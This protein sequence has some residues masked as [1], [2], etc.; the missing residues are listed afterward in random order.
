MTNS[1]QPP[2]ENQQLSET[3]RFSAY[4]VRNVVLQNSYS[5]DPAQFRDLTSKEPVLSV[6]AGALTGGAIG[7]GSTL[8]G[9]YLDP[10]SSP[11]RWEELALVALV[12][13]AS[14][15]HT[16]AGTFVN[17]HKKKLMKDIEKYFEDNPRE[18]MSIAD[19]PKEDD[20]GKK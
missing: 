19:S 7:W 5:L 16:L 3:M 20:D 1:E 11:E 10:Q 12:I 18:V 8:V 14:V 15:L 13:G 4:S 9:K 6:I 17:K 2:I